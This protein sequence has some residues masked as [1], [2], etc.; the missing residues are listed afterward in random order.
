MIRAAMADHRTDTRQL[1]QALNT[2][3]AVYGLATR[4]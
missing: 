4:H 2:L 1:H 3:A